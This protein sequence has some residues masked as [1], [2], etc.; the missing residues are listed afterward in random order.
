MLSRD[1]L[2]PPCKASL[3]N[4]HLS[5]QRRGVFGA[6]FWALVNITVITVAS[7]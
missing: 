4:T 6:E 1:S 7:A 5:G 2:P 3:K